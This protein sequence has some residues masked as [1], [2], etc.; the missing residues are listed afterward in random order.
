M[1]AT[2]STRV[3]W[4][5]GSNTTSSS[6]QPPV[7]ANNQQVLLE[8]SNFVAEICSSYPAEAKVEFKKP[9]QW[10]TTLRPA[11]VVE[12]DSAGLFKSVTGEGKT[13]G[14]VS[15]SATRADGQPVLVIEEI[16]LNG[17]GT[18]QSTGGS[19]DGRLFIAKCSN[20]EYLGKCLHIAGEGRLREVAEIVG[21]NR[22]P[23]NT[24]FGI[25]GGLPE[26]DPGALMVK[27]A[28]GLASE[29][30]AGKRE[31]LMKLFK[32][33]L[34]AEAWDLKSLSTALKAA[35]KDR[36]LDMHSIQTEM[37]LL[38]SFCGREQRNAL[39]S[40]DWESDYVFANGYRAPPWR[41]VVGE[42]CYV[43]VKPVDKETVVVAGTK[44]G[45]YTIKGYEKGT[46]DGAIRLN[47]E[48]TSDLFPT[49]IELLRWYSPHFNNTIDHQDYLYEPR[50]GERGVAL[51][52]MKD[53]PKKMS[54]PTEKRKTGAT[55]G[56]GDK[57]PSPVATK[58]NEGPS[59]KWK[60][61]GL[62]EDP[63][64]PKSKKSAHRSSGR[65]QER[66]DGRS[67]TPKKFARQ[68]S[69]EEDDYEETESEGSSEEE[70]MEKRQENSELPA[71][72]W[73]IQK[74]VKYLR[75]GNQTAT[76]IAIC[77][78]RDFDLSAETNQLAIRDVGGLDLL[79]NLLDTDDNKC[80]IGALE[81]LRD[82]SDN[83]Q[84][85]QAVA[86]LDGMQPLVEL[87]KDSNEEL[88]CL[89]AV[90]I[91]HCAR[92][93]RNRRAVRRY[94]GIRKLVRL[95]KM[96]AGSSEKVAISGALALMTC[97]KSAKNKRA[98]QD[99]GAVPLLANL[100][101]S[102]N[103]DVLVPVVGI[104]QE[105][106]EDENY[107]IAIRSSGMI[108]FLVGDLSSSNEELKKHAANAI[109]KCAE[110]AET[111]TLVRN[112]NGLD[113]LVKLLDNTA[114]KELLAA[115]TGAVW[116]CAQDLEN[117]GVFN[118]LAAIKKLVSLMENQPEEVLV[119]VVGALGACAQTAEGRDAIRGAGGITPLVNLLRGTN[120]A[121][122]VNVTTAVGACAKD[123]DSMGI[124]DKLDGVRL[125]WSL[126]KSPNPQVQA[127]A[128]W[129]ISPCI[130]HAKDAGEMVRSFVGGL[131]LIVSLLKSMDVQVL[132]SVCAAIANIAKDEENLAVITD[133][134]VVPMLAKLTNTKNDRL[135]R[136]LAE[137]VARCCRWGNNRVAFGTAG[138]V[139]PL[140]KYLKSPDEAVHRATAGALHQLSM[141][142]DN[143]VT[144]HEHGVVQL[145]LGMVG[146]QDAALQEAAAGTIGNIRRLALA[147]EKAGLV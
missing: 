73:A 56:S 16:S 65:S 123:G 18:S 4:G 11:V 9:L 110:D 64:P 74:L 139:A 41:Q 59:L 93:A 94:G 60:A 145:L 87:L 31:G 72:Y 113:P 58:P 117:V 55:V 112:Y 43:E 67:K 109:F 119:N 45:F 85:R 51:S 66:R 26:N 79:I 19:D 115:A 68:G 108:K 89:A 131:E 143:C 88:K 99:A 130:E 81:I 120:Q 77:A 98:I 5:F 132:A 138:A 104:L 40:I 97:S 125:L 134:G 12:S 61:L 24:V 30:D 70:M 21:A 52:S 75:V 141:D 128:A 95:L 44:K 29:A 36:H 34:L 96:T 83:V 122:L 78:L 63:R 135:R 33:L 15:S 102:K 133:H 46:Q 54:S 57:K 107:R 50:A 114:N 142:P 28:E 35:E 147:S 27:A 53:G 146:S 84:I 22:D 23:L 103:E 116:K 86:E 111:R 91:A 1:G 37:Q 25:T 92:N 48:K 80:K 137:A 136:H 49:L 20:F 129:A 38:Q 101:E 144:M 6:K 2:L 69:W 10:P 121:L 126:L 106:A 71:E 8:L 140:V 42:L 17:S 127:S 7:G 3:E 90:T 76:I 105:C 14:Y 124:I 47:Y 13:R 100:L 62:T 32:L 39:V 82:V 118:K